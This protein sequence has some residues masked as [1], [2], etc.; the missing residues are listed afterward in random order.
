MSTIE[1]DTIQTR[2]YIQTLGQHSIS[3]KPKFAYRKAPSIKSKLAPSKLKNK[4]P[5]PRHSLPIILAITGMYQCRKPLC[6]TCQ[7]VQHGQKEFRVKGKTYPIKEI[8]TCSS[9]YI[10]YSLTCPCGLFYVGQTIRTLR[11]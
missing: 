11:K 9:D 7:F 1:M 10:I 2:W 3:D 6:K 4:P 5:P 8:H